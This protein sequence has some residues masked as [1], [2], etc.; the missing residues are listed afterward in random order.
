MLL[1]ALLFAGILSA[2]EAV[3]DGAR[4]HYE[5]HGKGKDAVVFIHGWTCDLTFWKGQAPV[6]GSRR[7]LLIDLPGHGRSEKPQVAHTQE[8]F[9]R[10]IDA[11]MRDAGVERAVLVGHSMGGPVALTFLRLFPQKTRALVLVD[12]LLPPAPKDDAE[13]AKQKAGA[14]AALRAFSETE[15]Q[16][17]SRKMLESMFSDHTSTTLREDIRSKMMAAPHHVRLSALEGMLALEPPKP[18]DTYDL[19][20]LAVMA[21]RSARAGYEARLRTIFPRLTYQEWEG[22]GHFLMMEDPERFNATLS[23]FLRTV[24]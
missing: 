13:R 4:V 7:A 24:Q 12:S 17:T 3:Y 15:Y 23:G 18:G 11:V 20:V 14:E 6:Y 10:S 1:A 22:F 8:R 19:P 5:S 16:E 2:G 21:A 9:A